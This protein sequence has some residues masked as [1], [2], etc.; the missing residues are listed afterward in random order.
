MALLFLWIIS[1]F[2]Y[3]LP[4]FLAKGRKGVAIFVLN[5]L[6]GW[7]LIG[8]IFALVWAFTTEHEKKCH[9]CA[10]Y[11]LTTTKICRYCNTQLQS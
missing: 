8:W 9:N 4:T 1:F 5:L 11:I 3:F 2:I 6:L 10:E 7:T